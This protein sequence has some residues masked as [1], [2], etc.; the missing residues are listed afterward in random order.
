MLKI[1][2]MGQTK[3]IVKIDNRQT[4]YQMDFMLSLKYDAV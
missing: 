2:Q 3:Y 1:A 4:K